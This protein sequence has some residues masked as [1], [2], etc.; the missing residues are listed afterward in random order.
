MN[1]TIIGTGYV[2][3]ANAILLSKK[4][5]IVALDIDQTKVDRINNGISPIDDKDIQNELQKILDDKNRKN[6]FV[7]TTNQDFAIR[8]ADY[9]IIATP[10]NYDEISNSFD[11]NSIELVVENIIE[12]NNKCTVVIKS[13]VPI[14][15]T[16]NLKK[17]YSFHNIL[18]SP[19]F[20]REG[21]A[22]YDNLY[23][24]RIILG[25]D[26]K[27]AKKFGEMLSSCACKEKIDILYINNTEAEAVKLFANGYLAMRVAFFN[28]LDTYA[29][30]NGLN[31]SQI[32]EGV[33][34]DPRIGN[35]Y[36]NPSF[37]YG[38][39]CFPKDT[40]QLNANYNNIP[41]KI[42]SSIVDSNEVRKKFI[43][44]MIIQKKP[45]SVG[46]YRLI[47]KSGS[48]NFRSSAIIDIIDYL[49]IEGIEVLIFEP[50]IESETF[51]NC[52]IVNDFKYF[53]KNSS[54]IITNRIDK[55]LQ[56]FIKKVYTRD[57]FNYD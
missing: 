47:M 49:V 11:T 45:K 14:G 25:E 8:D 39:Y 4:N 42:I 20:L 48:D 12:K 19:E 2:G 17:K 44:N 40:K 23:P 41:N 33:S 32:I 56:P 54:I 27:R 38:G 21:R 22:L 29:E 34:L 3:M 26:T 31:A 10:T 16:E 36:N 13:T 35:F 1:I 7:A 6:S 52:K 9:I 24:S 43:S 46:V 15:Y 50:G 53:E 55:V 37:G 18:F 5:N 30:S 57:I 28:E 51:H